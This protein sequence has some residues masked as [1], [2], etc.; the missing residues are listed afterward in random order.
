MKEN[1]ILSN[2]YIEDF[3]YKMNNS[4]LITLK[5]YIEEEYDGELNKIYKSIQEKLKP[6]LEAFKEEYKKHIL[7]DYDNSCLLM[8][9]EKEDEYTDKIN[10]LNDEISELKYEINVLQD[11]MYECKANSVANYY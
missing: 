9:A 5:E 6:D 8:L 4:I 1:N 11:E 7:S 10:D 3:L 2:K